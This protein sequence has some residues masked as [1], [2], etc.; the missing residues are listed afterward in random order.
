[1]NFERKKLLISEVFKIVYEKEI[2]RWEE[3]S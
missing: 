2:T 1:L 3:M